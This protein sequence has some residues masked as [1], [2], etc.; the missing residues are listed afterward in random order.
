MRLFGILSIASLFCLTA[1][2]SITIPFGP[3]D[4]ANGSGQHSTNWSSTVLIP[5]FDGTLGTL[6][7]I[8]LTVWGIVISN[9]QFENQSGAPATIRVEVKGTLE[10]KQGSTQLVVTTPDY[11][12][13]DAVTAYDGTTDYGGTSG[14]TESNLTTG[15][16]SNSFSDSSLF[17]DL[18][19]WVDP[20]GGGGTVSLNL[21]ATGFT[22]GSGSSNLAQIIT[23]TASSYVTGDYIYDT[24]APEPAS[25]AV[26]GGGLLLLAAIRRRRCRT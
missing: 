26:A 17:D 23:T 11:V 4:P 16:Q 10:L 15:L 9:V 20:L 19:M 21:V 3:I 5:Q 7:Q 8:D 2:A 18:S 13:F 1:S 6:N 25:M 12:E 22:A 14:F 24:A